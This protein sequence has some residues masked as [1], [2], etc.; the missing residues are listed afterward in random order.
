MTYIIDRRQNGKGKSTEN[1]QKFMRRIKDVVKEQLPNIINNKKLVDIDKTG[2][3][4]K[5][6]ASKRIVEP[7]FRNGQGGVQDWVMPGNDEFTRNDQI[8]KPPSGGGRGR[9][10]GGSRGPNYEDEFTV[11]ISRQEFLDAFFEDL[12]LPDMVKTQ[13]S[14]VKEKVKRPAGYQPSGSPNKLSVLRSYKQSFLRKKPLEASLQ[15]KIDALQ[16]EFDASFDEVEKLTITEAIEKLVDKRNKIPFLDPVDLRYKL[17]LTE[18]V[19]TTHATMVM[20]MDNSGSM[21]LREKTIAR[22]FFYLLYAFLR[23]QYEEV[24][25]VFVSHT[26]E[27]EELNEEEFFNTSVAGGTVVSSALDLTAEII[28]ERLAGKTNIYISQV[29]DGDNENTDNGTCKEILEDDILPHVQYYAYV[30]VDDY[31]YTSGDMTLSQALGYAANNLW[32]AYEAVSES[33]K[34]LQMKR[35]HD[36]ADIFGVFKELFTKAKP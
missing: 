21:G 16:A 34:K 28:R 7:A 12:A 19:P 20:I 2:G 25:M 15:K 18:E 27:A 6:P 23:S 17:V 36:E 35:V 11:E 26:A 4:V 13:I 24:D 5:I 31:H 29:S 10:K 14:K 3:K 30:Q 32:K 1:R 9:G 33:N 8:D 22:K